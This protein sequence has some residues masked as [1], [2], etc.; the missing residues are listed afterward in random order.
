M[1]KLL[2]ISFGIIS[3]AVGYFHYSVTSA[4]ADD[5][6]F[7]VAPYGQLPTIS[8]DASLGRVEDAEVDVSIGDILDKL[9][10][11]GMLQVEAHHRSG[12]GFSLNYAFMK[13]EDT[14]SGPA[15]FT[16][17]DGDIFQGTL[18]GYLSY[19]LVS[20]EKN[21][22]IDFYGGARWWDTDIELSADNALGEV[23]VEKDPSWVD[24]VIGIRF[25]P[26]ISDQWRVLLQGDVGGFDVSSDSSYNLM[27]GVL[28]DAGQTF[29]VALLYRALWVDYSEGEA[30]NTDRFVYDTVTHG[31]LLGV[32]FRF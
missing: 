11:A 14:L 21:S 4:R 27:G 3:F 6:E 16:K 30:G 32:V 7:V 25:I 8:G 24:P 22:T 5:W 28:W 15:G 1:S 31:P 17:F 18:E 9:E 19:R 20:E 10:L 26:T 13:L 12:V 23:S 2:T 29:S